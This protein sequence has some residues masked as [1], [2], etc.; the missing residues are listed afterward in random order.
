MNNI[1]Q[2][3]SIRVKNIDE[4]IKFYSGVLGF[5]EKTRRQVLLSKISGYPLSK[6][7]PNTTLTL[8]ILSLDDFP[9]M[10]GLMSFGTNIPLDSAA[11]V[12]LSNDIRKIE[13]NF[14][15]FGGK[16]TMK[17]R[18]GSSINPNS[19]QKTPSYALMGLDPDE[20]FIEVIHFIKN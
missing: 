17:I 20:H 15:K 4:S 9:T 18:K 16:I 19:G 5:K 7:F 6:K 2:R 14:E 12:L 3:L 13:N 10:L 11:L 1:F 8:S